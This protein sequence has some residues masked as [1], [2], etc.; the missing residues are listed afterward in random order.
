MAN[1][2]VARSTALNKW[3]SDVG[4][5]KQIYKLGVTEGEPKAALVA[6]WAGEG[7]WTLVKAE[8]V[9]GLSEDQAIDRLAGKERMIDPNLYPKL[10]GVRGVFRLNQTRVEN[11]IV[12]TRA[13]AG[14]SDLKAL[15]LKP[16]DYA[17]Y[18][19]HNA[20]R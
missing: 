13:L 18:L 15:K 10:K 17:A 9:E 12:V 6:G 20:K 2:Y 8:P 1:L 3:A 19:I 4:L 11:H 14:D 16:I 5:G 7:D